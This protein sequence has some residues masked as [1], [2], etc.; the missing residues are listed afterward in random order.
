MAKNKS[1]PRL[2]IKHNLNDLLLIGWNLLHLI[3]IA[4]NTL[5]PE[6]FYIRWFGPFTELN[7]A[8]TLKNWFDPAL[9]VDFLKKLPKLVALPILQSSYPSRG[10]HWTIMFDHIIIRLKLNIFF[11]ITNIT[12]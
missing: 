7:G 4:F 6:E 1:R 11:I 9:Q 12:K 8:H 10:D 5:C 3:K 2:Q